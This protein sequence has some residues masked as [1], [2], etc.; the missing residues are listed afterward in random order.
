MKLGC[1]H[2]D[3]RA[4]WR[5]GRHDRARHHAA[6]EWKKLVFLRKVFNDPKLPPGGARSFSGFAERENG[7]RPAIFVPQ[8]PGKAGV[9]TVFTG[10]GMLRNW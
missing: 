4:R 8:R 6:V 7:R 5:W 10:S 2:P 9:F 3:F 1:N